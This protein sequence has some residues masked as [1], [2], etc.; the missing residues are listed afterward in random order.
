MDRFAF[1]IGFRR[2]TFYK[3]VAESGQIRKR[4]VWLVDMVAPYPSGEVKDDKIDFARAKSTCPLR[5]FP[6]IPQT[7]ERK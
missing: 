2:I 4:G 7:G 5:P 1:I 3:F 6:L